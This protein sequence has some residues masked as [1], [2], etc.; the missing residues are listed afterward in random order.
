MPAAIHR[1][2]SLRARV[3][4]WTGKTRT[5]RRPAMRALQPMLWGSLPTGIL[6]PRLWVGSDVQEVPIRAAAESLSLWR[7]AKVPLTQSM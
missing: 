5:S 6:E 2:I 3:S 1:F 7:F 4:G